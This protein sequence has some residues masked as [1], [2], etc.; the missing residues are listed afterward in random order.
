MTKA[1]IKNMPEDMTE[2]YMLADRKLQLLPGLVYME[3]AIQSI[4]RPREVS[5]LIAVITGG[6]HAILHHYI[7]LVIHSPLPKGEL[8]S[9]RNVQGI[10]TIYIWKR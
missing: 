6:L 7:W 4:H 1:L 5:L 10:S 9:P 8:V 3:R 2:L